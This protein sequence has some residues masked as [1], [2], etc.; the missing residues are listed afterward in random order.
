[1]ET[2]ILTNL[3]KTA[4][5]SHLF[6]ASC[7]LTSHPAIPTLILLV[8]N[9]LLCTVKCL[10][11]KTTQKKMEKRVAEVKDGLFTELAETFIVIKI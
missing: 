6:T 9:E 7:Q 2:E 4:Y 10:I 11:Y 8:W 5:F 3:R 1:M